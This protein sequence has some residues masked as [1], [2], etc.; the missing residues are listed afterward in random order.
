[1]RRI[2]VFCGANP[3]RDPAFADSAREVGTKLSELG[4][5][6][7]FGGGRVGLMGIVADA[8]IE[9][10]GEV[11]GVIPQALVDRELAHPGA[12]EM[13][14]VGSMHER[15]QLMHALSDGFLALPGGL[16][17]LDELFETLTW[18]QLGI[19][20]KPSGLLNV[21]GYYD[22][23]LQLLE[24]GFAQGLI[25]E[26]SRHLL[27]AGSSVPD[28]VERLRTWR[29]RGDVRWSTDTVRP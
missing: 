13:H 25:P 7:V 4:I 22:P 17:T 28:L 15:K 9:A 12:T 1:M 2:C 21:D 11:I 23:L 14:R 6:V 20:P 18:G 26:S 27:L 5:G 3:G 16:G 24:R 8:V 29:P 10:G 19:H